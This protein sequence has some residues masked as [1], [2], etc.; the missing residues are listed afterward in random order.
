[1]Q[2]FGIT[3]QHFNIIQFPFEMKT[4]IDISLSQDYHVAIY[5]QKSSRQYTNEKILALTHARLKEMKNTLGNKIAK[6]IA[7]LCGNGS[8]K[9]WTNII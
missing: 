2:F 6:S 4:D 3:S 9:Y 8:T 7:I 1:M 5:F